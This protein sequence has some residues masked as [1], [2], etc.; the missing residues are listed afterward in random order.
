MTALLF[1]VAHLPA[2]VALGVALAVGVVVGIVAHV[3]IARWRAAIVVGVLGA[4]IASGGGH[5]KQTANLYTD[6]LLLL[7]YWA[8]P[9][10]AVVFI[11][12]L[13]RRGH[14]VPPQELE[15]GPRFRTGLYAWIIGLAASIPFWDQAWYTGPFAAA[16]PQFGDLSYY[17]GF[18][19]AAIIMIVTTPK[20]AASPART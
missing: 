1:R 9:W 14:T 6:F 2:T 8:S 13:H 18:I 16:Y 12:W 17:V 7:S 5:P 19:V 4:L 10:A 15:G 11:D 3:R 20:H